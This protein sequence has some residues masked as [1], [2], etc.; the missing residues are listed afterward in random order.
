MNHRPV[1][2][3]TAF[4]HAPAPA[5][6]HGATFGG[7]LQQ[8]DHDHMLPVVG[9]LLAVALL[10]RLAIV[11]ITL[12]V[13]IALW[14]FAVAWI[15]LFWA[16]IVLFEWTARFLRACM[17][18]E[19]L[20]RP[21]TAEH[22]D[23][24]HHAN[25]DEHPYDTKHDTQ[26]EAIVTA[27]DHLATEL[28]AVHDKAALASKAD[29]HVETCAHDTSA[30][31]T[32]TAAELSTVEKTNTHTERSPEAQEQHLI[33]ESLEDAE[34]YVRKIAEQRA[35][36]DA[37]GKEKENVGGAETNAAH[38]GEGSSTIWQKPLDARDAIGKT[39]TEN[40]DPGGQPQ[41]HQQGSISNGPVDSKSRV[42]AEVNANTKQSPNAQAPH[43]RLRA[44]AASGN[45]SGKSPMSADKA[46]TSKAVPI[47]SRK[48]VNPFAGPGALEHAKLFMAEVKKNGTFK[49][50]AQRPKQH[51]GPSQYTRKTT[52]QVV[53]QNKLDQILRSP[54]SKEGLPVTPAET[55]IIP[56]HLRR[57]M[58]ATQ[59]RTT[60]RST[61]PMRQSSLVSS[62]S[63]S[64]Q[65]EP[66]NLI[67]GQKDGPPAA[68][69]DHKVSKGPAE[70][71][72]R[73]DVHKEPQT[74]PPPITWSLYEL[75]GLQKTCGLIPL[76]FTDQT[77]SNDR[78]KPIKCLKYD[79][80]AH[81]STEV[82]ANHES[83]VPTSKAK[84]GVITYSKHVLKALRVAGKSSEQ[85][86]LLPKHARSTSGLK[87]FQCLKCWKWAH[88][89]AEASFDHKRCLR[90]AVLEELGSHDP[91]TEPSDA[92]A[93]DAAK[94]DNGRGGQVQ[95]Q[96]IGGPISR[97]DCI[98]ASSVDKGVRTELATQQ[99]PPN[100]ID[101]SGDTPLASGQ[102]PTSGLA[103]TA[104]AFFVPSK[105]S[106]REPS[107]EEAVEFVN[108]PAF[109]TQLLQQKPTPLPL[110][111]SFHVPTL[112]GLGM[113][114]TGRLPARASVQGLF[115]AQPYG[116]PRFVPAS[117]MASLTVHSPPRPALGGFLPEW[118]MQEASTLGPL[119]S[120]H[121]AS[122]SGIA[123]AQAASLAAASYHAGLLAASTTATQSYSAA[124]AALANPF[125]TTSTPNLAQMSS[126]PYQSSGW[127]AP[128]AQT[129]S[130]S[131][132]D[133]P[134][135]QHSLKLFR[136]PQEALAAAQPALTR[137]RTSLA[138]PIK[139]PAGTEIDAQA[140]DPFANPPTIENKATP[141]RPPGLGLPKKNAQAAFDALISSGIASS[142]GAQPAK[143]I[144]IL[145]SPDER[146]HQE[147]TKVKR[148]NLEQPV[149]TQWRQDE[150]PTP[151]EANMS[152]ISKV[153]AM[154]VK[155]KERSEVKETKKEAR[156]ALT[157]AWFEREEVRKKLA[158]TFDLELAMKMQD[159][160]REYHEKRNALQGL[161]G[162]GALNDDDAKVFPVLG[163]SNLTVPKFRPQGHSEWQARRAAKKNSPRTIEKDHATKQ[164]PVKTTVT[165]EGEPEGE[166][167]EAPEEAQEE[168]P[169]KVPEEEPEGSDELKDLI[170]KM[171]QAK[172]LR[173][174]SLDYFNQ[175]RPNT[176]VSYAT[177]KAKG[178]SKRV[179]ADKF[180]RLK[181]QALGDYFPNGMPEDLRKE[182]PYIL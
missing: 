79:G 161:M 95:A 60:D 77:K 167:E 97:D 19:L 165:A 180:Y 26:A 133:E 93:A 11:I 111:S 156:I 28:A 138:V 46:P 23:S 2:D 155:S 91:K 67:V 104:P 32:S 70:Q 146:Q 142:A 135:A 20:A 1:M 166:G 162:T 37:Q 4:D 109:Q 177:W 179:R 103:P 45:A 57:S 129:P 114:P 64:Y 72:S 123:P 53:P 145:E 149:N 151:A 105:P 112:P 117:E 168:A 139:T 12:F 49:F 119:N 41:K 31:L 92:D 140:R 147:V 89:S 176:N 160:T 118:F 54:A 148:S 98:R 74:V 17:R 65:H 44:A 134:Q 84:A 173:R 126:N 42:F 51:Q 48:S 50:P 24:T 107:S 130:L 6:E 102:H 78:A 85:L 108:R 144:D 175:P 110:T 25:T 159:L 169:E 94:E 8:L 131:F 127:E 47:Q 80:W 75:E 90:C 137:R 101:V 58:E 170:E 14:C 66:S 43:L 124:P 157:D 81:E 122:G 128:V 52:T 71:N 182:Y 141:P 34:A 15:A 82:P 38:G 88:E 100:P 7:I 120:V 27:T 39:E 63:S 13:I 5:V 29:T 55:G 9:A 121:Y 62:Q 115:D 154:P 16:Q 164:S 18:D 152:S 181:L 3:T 86:D 171:E 150:F 59:R 136:P 106:S 172:V 87:M 143:L 76:S 163:L 113:A 83:C 10:I 132:Q 174:D 73:L 178:E 153:E 116:P 96:Q 21:E 125:H 22:V 56:P 33:I 68:V 69:E 61:P 158:Q 40:T 99:P 36:A 35:L 30:D